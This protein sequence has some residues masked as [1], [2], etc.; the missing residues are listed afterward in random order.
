[1]VDSIL[2]DEEA[3]LW[4][5]KFFPQK[6]LTPHMLQ[7]E[8]ETFTHSQCIRS[9]YGAAFGTEGA[10]ERLC[11]WLTKFMCDRRDAIELMM[12]LRRLCP[13]PVE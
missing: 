6:Q 8:A 13:K 10:Q 5:E 9:N 4:A 3:G 11:F 7:D 2:G 1:M 12:R